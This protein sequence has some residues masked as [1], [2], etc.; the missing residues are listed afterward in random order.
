MA[1]AALVLATDACN[2]TFPG[3]CETVHHDTQ[4]FETQ[5]A[6][7][8]VEWDHDWPVAPRDP[9]LEGGCRAS[10]EAQPDICSAAAA[11]PPTLRFTLTCTRDGH[12]DAFGL[13]ATLTDVRYSSA[14]DYP[15]DVTPFGDFPYPITT[16]TLH[17]ESASGS[18]ASYP[19]LVT[20]DFERVLRIEIVADTLRASLQFDV[21]ADQFKAEPGK[22]C[23]F[24]S[25]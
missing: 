7:G 23:Q 18:A 17:V 4:H 5:T 13:F 6:T 24:C 20:P 11:P 19:Q 12:V 22:V 15:L 8:W 10:L 2:I 14:G 1:G 9:P 16:N 3:D 25:E 21:K